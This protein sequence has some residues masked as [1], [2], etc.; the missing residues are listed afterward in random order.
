MI[1]EN[2]FNFKNTTLRVLILEDSL[3]DLE[4]MTE[5]LLNAG[6]Q[7]EVTHA[8][9]ETGFR[10]ALT[11][12]EFDIILSDYNLPGFNAFG[13]L[14]ISFEICPEVPFICVS[15]SIG[16]ET[17]I[18]LLKKGAVDYVLK[19]R[20]GRL[21]FA[22]QRALAGVKEKAFRIKADRELKES[23]N[24]F[25]QVAETAQEWIWEI[26]TNGLYTYASPVI[27]SLLG[28]TPDEVVGK[29]YFYDLYPPEEKEELKRDVFEILSKKGILKNFVNAHLHK[30][31][32]LVYIS[33][34]GSPVFDDAGNLTGYRG[35]DEDITERKMA[36]EL[37]KLNEKKFHNLFYYHS[38][39]KLIID[40]ETG[41]I[42]E[43]NK[44]AAAFYGWPEETLQSMNISQINA[45]HPEGV[46]KEIENA[47][48]LKKT[49]F[50]FQ[51]RKADDS[52]VDVE[53]FSSR[54]E[55][56]SKEFLHSIVH[57][58]SEKKKAEEKLKLLNR[59]VEASSVSV[60]IT[61]ADGNINYVN[62][63][64]TELTGYSYEETIGK[65]PRILK[66]G[67]QPKEFYD[68]LWNTINSGKDWAGEFLNRK[69]NGELYWESGVIS[70]IVNSNGKVTNFVNIK[71]DITHK[72]KML[73]DLVAAKEKAEES[74][75]LK[76]AFINN[77]SHEIRTPLNGI[78]GFGH[79]IAEFDLSAEKRREYFKHINHSSDRLLNTIT[80]Y[81]DM[82]MIVS[83]T[84]KVNKKE[85]ILAPV[86]E[87]ITKKTKQLC[88]DQKINFNIEIPLDSK[89]LI[90]YSNPEFIQK[91]LRK[92]LDNAIKFTREG[93][94]S[95]GYKIKTEHIEFFVK[96]TGS[97]I[98]SDKL[99]VIFEMFSQ[100]DSS[101][102]RE[103]DGNGLG[104]SIAKDLATL[105]GGKIQATSEKG[106]GSEFTFTIPNHNSKTLRSVNNQIKINNN[107]QPLVL[108]VED[109]KLSYLFL[110][111]ILDRSGYNNIRAINGLEAVNYCTQNPDIS[112]VLMDIQMPVMNGIEATRQIREYKPGLPIIATTAHAQ[113]GDKH[114]F[115]EAG[116]SDYLSKPIKKEKLL[117]L[118]S[119]TLG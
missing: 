92:L 109:D 45:L 31:G 105:I 114:R 82:A 36:E 41:N 60:I 52:L 66:S 15:G 32:Q 33:T 90:V 91:I 37:L 35:A 25:R 102:T 20:P 57:D 26:D 19:D 113:T 64:F 17:A 72:K 65:N 28:Y 94:I 67:N 55:I 79:L 85:F 2:D 76:T 58:I 70:P 30:N 98:D 49:N 96:D 12:K 16:E 88:A 86:F 75:K 34:S 23:E 84:M 93:S 62:P 71:E 73:E 103:Y 6:Y 118:I 77:I 42:V 39:V 44:A 87:T 83:K 74:D 7:I 89:D 63:Y 80:D 50:E 3:M 53:V 106:K 99:N 68:N 29:K 4:L 108:I 112:I 27:E 116:C 61:N 46:K 5:Q 69:K 14:E 47:R 43:A 11:K 22:V 111:T 54:I 110:K 100:E 104:L 38:A 51:H 13:A 9:E 59:A 81:M 48:T 97:G 115:I 1:M 56:D 107:D 101:M 18:E 95:C 8:E 21:P 78:L 117:A 40:P 10:E 24:R 119:S